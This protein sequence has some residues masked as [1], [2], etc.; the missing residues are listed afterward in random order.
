MRLTRS[1]PWF[2]RLAKSTARIHRQTGD[3]HNRCFG[4]RDMDGYGPNLRIQRYVAARHQYRNHDHHFLD[5]L[6]HTSTQ[7]RDLRRMQVK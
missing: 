4:C 1:K 2:S 6:S 7:N 3:I 5:G